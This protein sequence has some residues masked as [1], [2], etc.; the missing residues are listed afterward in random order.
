MLE[1]EVHLSAV[2]CAKAR[3][4]WLNLRQFPSLGNKVSSAGVLVIIVG[5]GNDA[6]LADRGYIPQ[7]ACCTLSSALG[8]GVALRYIIS[9]SEINFG[10]KPN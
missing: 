10:M 4:S 9:A 6:V 2:L 3:L 8:I 5:G 7:N 1:S